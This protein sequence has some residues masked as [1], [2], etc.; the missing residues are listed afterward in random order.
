LSP[1]LKINE[2]EALGGPARRPNLLGLDADD[3]AA[4]R[5]DEE[6]VLGH[7]RN[8]TAGPIFGVILRLITPY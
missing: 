8:A 2:A 4:H 6:V 5:D 3:L 7:L 1:S